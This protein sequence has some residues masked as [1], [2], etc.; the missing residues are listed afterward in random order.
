MSISDQDFDPVM[1]IVT[2]RTGLTF[3][4][5]LRAH[6]ATAVGQSVAQ[7][8]VLRLQDYAVG[9]ASGAIPL[10]PLIE[11]ITIKE[12]YF[13]REPEQ[14]RLIGD[15]ILAVARPAG[16][17]PFR[18]W[19]AGCATGEEPYSL[20]VLAEEFGLADRCD[21]LGTDL[22]VE[23]LARAR[24]GAYR[25]WSYRT[26]EAERV[27]RHCTPDGEGTHVLHPRFRQ[28]VRFLRHNLWCD[29][30]PVPE[31]G[32]GAFDLILCRNV[33]L[34]FGEAARQAIGHRLASALAEGGWLI[35]GASDPPLGPLPS[36]ESIV[37][38]AGLVYR[39]TSGGEPK[40][41]LDPG[42]S[43]PA[44]A[45]ERFNPFEPD[46]SGPAAPWDDPAPVHSPIASDSAAALLEQM[47]PVPE[48]AAGA[49]PPAFPHLRPAR[50]AGA[51][52]APHVPA[53]GGRPPETL[54]D[55]E[56]FLRQHPF[57][58]QTH[59]AVTLL[60]TEQGR[61]AEAAE[62]ARRLLYLDPTL[63]I[64]HFT[65]GLVSKALGQPREAWR[66]FR[67]A[68]RLCAS[69]PEDATLPGTEGARAGELTRAARA[70]L[71]LLETTR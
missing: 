23:A 29:P 4:A 40:S 21:I 25:R 52:A 7:A 9:I 31:A 48:S 67:G 66:A 24:L 47:W 53:A 46:P 16:G 11:R 71:R 56:R 44:A 65:L 12:T 41:R 55:A 13:F 61:Y 70:E 26:P 34:Y 60:L 45:H 49:E 8:G 3:P 57:D 36:C 33:L 38:P 20:A 35:P 6:V 10:D 64:A 2:A 58:M 42:A 28:R 5:V 27:L 17:R 15:E 37:T 59:L 51:T 43:E 63:P 69:L 39:R 62:S 1:D 14:Y 18:I 68:V 54:A 19:C 32:D 22:S 30:I 50:P